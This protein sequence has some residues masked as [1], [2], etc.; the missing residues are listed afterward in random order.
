MWV[1]FEAAAVEIE[2]A[3][4][5]LERGDARSAWALAQVPLNIAAAVCCRARR[6]SWLEPLRRE[7]EDIRLRALEVIGRAGLTPGRQRSWPPSSAPR[8]R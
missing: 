8:G 7:L 2:R 6:R 4:E 1:D 3:Q 5:A